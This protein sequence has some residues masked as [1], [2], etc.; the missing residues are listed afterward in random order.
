MHNGV[1]RY[2]YYVAQ[3]RKHKAKKAHKAV[4]AAWDKLR[5]YQKAAGVARNITNLRSGLTADCA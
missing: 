2:A 4:D 1:L 3:G 5:A